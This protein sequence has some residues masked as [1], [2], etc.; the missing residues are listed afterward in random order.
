[1]DTGRG[2][3]RVQDFDCIEANTFRLTSI[4]LQEIL[5][6]VSLVETVETNTPQ[7][8]QG[9]Q[10]FYELS[11]CGGNT[12]D[13]LEPHIYQ[14]TIACDTQNLYN[15]GSEQRNGQNQIAYNLEPLN[16][17]IETNI[18]FTNSCYAY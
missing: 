17:F 7:S 2:H 13:S 5:F 10:D 4:Q 11:D 8:S 18:L 3:L 12:F 16:E 9:F 14:T 1:M 6:L 15:P